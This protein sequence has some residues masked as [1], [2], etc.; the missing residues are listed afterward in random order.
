MSQD[1]AATPEKVGGASGEPLF[2]GGGPPRGESP[3]RVCSP[4]RDKWKTAPGVL[5]DAGMPLG[6][7]ALVYTAAAAF[8]RVNEARVSNLS[9]T[10]KLR[11]P[12]RPHAP[13]GAF[14]RVRKYGKEVKAFGKSTRTHG[15]RIPE[16]AAASGGEERAFLGEGRD[17]S[18]TSDTDRLSR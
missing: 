14:D 7:F 6:D 18:V 2:T 9:R 17:G 11:G 1:A 10:R 8:L 16:G 15:R 3:T 12:R 13:R 4:E 5:I